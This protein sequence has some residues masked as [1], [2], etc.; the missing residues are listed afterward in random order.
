VPGGKAADEWKKALNERKAK[1]GLQE[2]DVAPAFASLWASKD[3]EE[4][5][6]SVGS[7]VRDRR[8]LTLYAPTLLENDQD[9]GS[10]VF[11][12]HVQVL[13]R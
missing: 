3:D 11:R 10:T 12:H 7:N 8:V 4:Q 6:R 5:V 1:D 2:I 9:S 13:C